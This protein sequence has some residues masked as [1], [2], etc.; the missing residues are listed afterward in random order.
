MSFTDGV[1][2]FIPDKTQ[3][4]TVQHRERRVQFGDGYSQRL[5]L[6][7][8][9]EIVVFFRLRPKEEAE[10]LSD[11]FR[12]AQNNFTLTLPSGDVKV[13]H[14]RD[15][16]VLHDYADFYSVSATLKTDV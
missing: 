5:K 15:F 4:Q 6:K 13:V 11:F 12:R 9:E 16:M 10:Q 2:T 14:C 8:V 3:T 1:N 7:P